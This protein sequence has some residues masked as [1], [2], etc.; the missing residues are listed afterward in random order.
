METAGWDCLQEYLVETAL[1][2][3]AGGSKEQAVAM[4]TDL[5]E[6]GTFSLADA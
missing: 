5:V 4:E 2:P 1:S 3:W 6:T